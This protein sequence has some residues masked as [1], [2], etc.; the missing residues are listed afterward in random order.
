MQCGPS[1]LESRQLFNF[2]NFFKLTFCQPEVNIYTINLK[3][4][5]WAIGGI[6]FGDR[7]K[8]AR[9]RAGLSL[10]D[11]A[12]RIGNDVSAQAISKYESGKMFPSSSV[13]VALGRALDVS[14]D[15]LMSN[16]VLAIEGVEFRQ[17]SGISAADRARAE[18][19]VI[20]EIE[21]HLALDAVLGL[22]SEK[23]ELP[24][25]R[26]TVSSLEEVDDVA[27]KL[28]S[29]WKLGNDPIPSMT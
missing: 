18:S 20:D 29:K 15:F 17:H 2:T 8:L 19:I 1:P 12:N 4:S 13:L 16:Q 24:R 3:M 14:L 25:G 11:L 9:K 10:R 6:M 5:I 27:N 22:D 21:R 23:N 28:R 7:L 26:V